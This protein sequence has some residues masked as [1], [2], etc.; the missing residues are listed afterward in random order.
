MLHLDLPAGCDFFQSVVLLAL[1][2]LSLSCRPHS[3]RQGAWCC[4][5]VGRSEVYCIAVTPSS[6]PCSFST[7]SSIFRSPFCFH[8]FLLSLSFS[9]P[10]PRML[11]CSTARGFARG[12]CTRMH[13][14]RWRSSYY[15]PHAPVSR[16]HG[17]RDK[18]I[19]SIS[20]SR[21]PH[22]WLLTQGKST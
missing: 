21:K 4:Q 12:P 17:H 14:S 16:H 3:A 6:S 2:I 19:L 22:N 7:P 10:P 8:T 13:A 20:K 5:Y 18:D 15:A 9:S 11:A 1:L